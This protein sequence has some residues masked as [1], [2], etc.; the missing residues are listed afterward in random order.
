M[1]QLV[2]DI[3]TQMSKMYKILG[4]VKRSNAYQKAVNVISRYTKEN[5]LMITGS[6]AV[7]LKGVGKKLSR[8]IDEIN[9]TGQL[10]ELDEL[11]KSDQFLTVEKFSSIYGVGYIRALQWYQD[12]FREFKD[13]KDLTKAQRLYLD[14][15]DELRKKIKR[16]DIYRYYYKLSTMVENFDNKYIFE[17]TGSYKR[18]EDFSN[19]IDLVVSYIGKSSID[20]FKRL[21]KYL[22][23]NDLILNKLSMGFGR[24]QG[25]CNIEI[26]EDVEVRRIDINYCDIKDFNMCIAHTSNGREKNMIQRSFARSQWLTINDT[27]VRLNMYGI[28]GDKLDLYDS[29]HMEEKINWV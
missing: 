17:L 4:D 18:G 8:R 23:E 26:D 22:T 12:G 7:K 1:N 24:Y 16:S 15:Y 5:K 25:M 21:I 9:L 27:G 11:K 2:M 29:D 28:L 20:N 3:F 13:L 14:D 19:D 6:E 10:K